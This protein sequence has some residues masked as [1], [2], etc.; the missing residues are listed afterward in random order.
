MR[1]TG[2]SVQYLKSVRGAKTPDYILKNDKTDLIIEIGGKS[3]GR[4]QFK[5]IH[6]AKGII[7]SH[8][9]ETEDIRRPLFLA[10]ML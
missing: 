5:G 4:E 8:S 6:G 9:L 10:G 7:L 1:M 3:K 2:H